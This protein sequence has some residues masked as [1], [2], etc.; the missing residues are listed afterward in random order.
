MF[1][2]FIIYLQPNATKKPDPLIGP[3][4]LIV[5]LVYPKE[6]PCIAAANCFSRSLISATSF[7]ASPN[8]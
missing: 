5:V 2:S 6:T 7:L 3:V 4:L 1:F 8:A